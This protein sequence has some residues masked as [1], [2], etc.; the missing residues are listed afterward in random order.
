L[1]VFGGHGGLYYLD[2]LE[3]GGTGMIPGCDLPEVYSH[4]YDDYALG[5]HDEARNRFHRVL[6]LIVF[7]FQGLDFFISSVK[8]ILVELGVIERATLRGVANSLG[9][10]SARLL[11]SHARA[12]GVLPT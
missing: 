7:E 2:V 5:K 8:T 4:I 3:A 10:V 6:P 11:L 9:P 12:A 1:T